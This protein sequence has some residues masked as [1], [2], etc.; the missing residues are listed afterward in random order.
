[1][2][3]VGRIVVI[4]LRLALLA[5]VVRPSAVDVVGILG[6]EVVLQLLGLVEVE[7]LL[8][9]ECGAWRVSMRAR[10]KVQAGC[11]QTISIEFHSLLRILLTSPVRIIWLAAEIWGLRL[12]AKI[13]NA[14][15]GRLGVPSALSVCDVSAWYGSSARR[16]VVAAA[17][18]GI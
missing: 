1:M 14:F 7:L 4:R 11:I 3:A 16:A 15:M 10:E 9:L 13:M 18:K 5:R 8:R 17:T 2:G 12:R 6:I